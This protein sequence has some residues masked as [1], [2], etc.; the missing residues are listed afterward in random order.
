MNSHAHLVP[1]DVWQAY[2]QVSE[3][4]G[5]WEETL[6]RY[7]VNTIVIDQ[8]YREALIKKLKENDKWKLDFEQDGE[9]VFLRKTPL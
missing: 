6:D 8:M 7:G 9:L 4:Q 2:L 1:R 3:V 5:G